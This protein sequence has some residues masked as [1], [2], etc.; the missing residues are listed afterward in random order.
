MKE[1]SAGAFLKYFLKNVKISHV[2]KREKNPLRNVRKIIKSAIESR[3][4]DLYNNFIK[5]RYGSGIYEEK[6]ESM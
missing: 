2:E 6:G 1:L 3:R 5:K 4:P